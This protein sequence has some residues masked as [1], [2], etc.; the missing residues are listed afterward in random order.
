MPIHNADIATVFSEIADLLEIRGDNPFRIRAYRNAAVSVGGFGQDIR[1]LFGR[2]GELPKLPGIG[3][4]LDAK[5]ICPMRHSSA[6]TSWS[7]RCTAVS[8]FPGAGRPIG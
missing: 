8:I 7:A 4:D 5:R 2:N 6:L 3:P 1:T